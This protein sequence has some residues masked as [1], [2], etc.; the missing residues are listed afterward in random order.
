MRKRGRSPSGPCKKRDTKKKIARPGPDGRRCIGLLSTHRVKSLEWGQRTSG[1]KGC[2]RVRFVSGE[3]AATSSK[4]TESQ[5]YERRQKL[6]ENVHYT[7]SSTFLDNMFLLQISSKC[8]MPAHMHKRRRSYYRLAPWFS[9]Y[10]L[11]G[12]GISKIWLKRLC[13]M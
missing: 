6:I 13:W 9:L 4:W 8:Q 3:T 1:C 11:A 12:C 2:A 10:S 5:T 7:N